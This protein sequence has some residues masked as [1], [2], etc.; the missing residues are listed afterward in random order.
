MSTDSNSNSLSTIFID[1]PP[2][3]LQFCPTAPY[4][5][6]I[7]TYLLTIHESDANSL[8]PE[9]SRSGSLQLFRLNPQSYHLSQVQRLSL[10]HAV[11]DLQF[12]LHDPS[13]FAVAL[14]AGKVSL[15]RVESSSDGPDADVSTHFLNTLNV[16]N[17]DTNLSLFLAW[18]PPLPLEGEH[19][20]PPATGFAVSFSDG[21]VSV[22]Q[23]DNLSPTLQQES[24]K[25][26]RLE[27]MSIEVWYLAFH[28][29]HDG[30]LSLFSGDDFNQV[31]E[32][33][34]TDDSDFNIGSP[35]FNDRGKFHEGGVTAILPLCNR[36]EGSIILTGSYDQHVR[37][38]RFGTRRQ[39]LASMDLGGGVW[40]LKLLRVEDNP[41]PQGALK[42][43]AILASCMHGG[44]RVIRVAHHLK[45]SNTENTWDIEIVARF[46]EHES[47]NYA[48]DVWPG[49]YK[50]SELLCLSS[51]FYDKR[52]PSGQSPQTF[53]P[54]SKAKALTN[55]DMA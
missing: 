41:E 51:S 17:G 15:Y 4:F 45:D 36:D 25:E 6:V 33:T 12:S 3:C 2:S 13:L 29:R 8:S 16:R 39:V 48:S 34:F 23:K 24:L 37:V 47:M 19:D 55:F 52:V 1:Q 40:R 46:T 31:R 21:Q 18:I 28:R 9:S 43:Y 26:T 20:R 11:F 5:L 7:G 22:F 49:Y 50:P 44:A 35:P 42:S 38:Y 27:G 14:S 54:I 32:F 10:S 53:G 30:Q